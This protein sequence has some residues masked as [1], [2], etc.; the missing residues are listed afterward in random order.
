[1]D[2]YKT[3]F[4]IYLPATKCDEKTGKPLNAEYIATI[5]IDVYDKFGMQMMTEQSHLVIERFKMNYL[6]DFYRKNK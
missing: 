3:D 2:T 6:M 1:M 5:E 4:K